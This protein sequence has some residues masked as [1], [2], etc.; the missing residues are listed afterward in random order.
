MTEVV[1]SGV[2]AGFEGDGGP[3]TEAETTYPYGIAFDPQGRLLL[4]DQGNNRVRRVDE[5]GVISTIAGSGPTGISNGA[6]GGDGGPATEALLAEPTAIAVDAEGNIFVSDPANARVRRIGTDGVITTVAGNGEL[7]F[8]LSAD[9]ADG[10]PA[11]EVGLTAGG[12]AVDAEGRAL[13]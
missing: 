6:Y 10:E 3:A 4:A 1:G 2:A 7:M 11:T 12:L 13:R 5:A 8:S 9:P